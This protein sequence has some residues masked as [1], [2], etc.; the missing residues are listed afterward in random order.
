MAGGGCVFPLDIERRVLARAALHRHPGQPAAGSAP[1]N[2]ILR[3]RPVPTAEKK[4]SRAS[5]KAVMALFADIK[6]LDG[7]DRER[8]TSNPKRCARAPSSEAVG[9]NHE[10]GTAGQRA[11]G[12]TTHL[13]TPRPFGDRRTPS[14]LKG[15]SRC[16]ILVATRKILRARNSAFNAQALSSGHVGSAASKIHLK[17]GSARSVRHRSNPRRRCLRRLSHATAA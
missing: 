8:R 11:V 4:W 14:L 17:P 10:K 6:E 1:L 12:G 15:E 3:W 9:L 2:V 7:D 16:A 13:K 5:A